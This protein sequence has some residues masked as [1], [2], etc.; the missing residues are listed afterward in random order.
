VISSH[1]K[2]GVEMAREKRLPEEIIDII[3]QHHGTC[4]ISFFFQQAQAEAEAKGGTEVPEERFRYPGPKPQAT[5]SAIVMLSDA[6]EAAIR[7]Q[8]Q[9]TPK[10]IENTVNNIVE[11]RLIDGQFEQ[12]NIT[13][14]QIDTVRNSLIK[15][16]ATVYHSRMEYPDLDELRRH[17]DVGTKTNGDI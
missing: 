17:R 6:C 5:E 12:C 10:S 16:L 8:K 3:A 9:P 11:A 15:T 2:D 7:S 13:L 4:L 14:K 1:A